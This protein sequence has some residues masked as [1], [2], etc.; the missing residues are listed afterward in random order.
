[1]DEDDTAGL[2]VLTA[3]P[4][5]VGFVKVFNLINEFSLALTLALS[6]F[7]DILDFLLCELS[8]SVMAEKQ[9]DLDGGDPTNR[10]VDIGS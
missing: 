8:L 10:F 9:R 4:H 7:I 2:L 5:A 1:M 3:S 6:C